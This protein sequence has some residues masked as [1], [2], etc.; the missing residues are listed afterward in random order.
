MTGF[1]ESWE[2]HVMNC[3]SVTVSQSSVAV[4]ELLVWHTCTVLVYIICNFRAWQTAGT[5]SVVL[6]SPHLFRLLFLLVDVVSKLF[7]PTIS[8]AIF[9]EVSVTHTMAHCQ[10][11]VFSPSP[12]GHPSLLCPRD[13]EVGPR[14]RL[15]RSSRRCSGPFLAT[16]PRL[17]GEVGAAWDLPTSS[18]SPFPGRVRPKDRF[19]S[20]CPVVGYGEVSNSTGTMAG[21]PGEWEA[22]APFC[23]FSLA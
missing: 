21:C 10:Q 23:V 1:Y 9:K 5:T 6:L 11:N 19:H 18:Y 16:S 7:G 4:V 17:L 14:R 8:G 2:F 12:S 20:G 15:P 3:V 13:R 22:R